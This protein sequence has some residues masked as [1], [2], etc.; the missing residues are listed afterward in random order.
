MSTASRAKMFTAMP[1]R[2]LIS[3]LWLLTALTAAE[4]GCLCKNYTK[5]AFC[6]ENIPACQHK[7][8]NCM[9]A[10]DFKKETGFS[11]LR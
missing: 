11:Y 5:D 3:G 2:I 9:D 6:V 7:A 4:A 1:S 8:G 10:C